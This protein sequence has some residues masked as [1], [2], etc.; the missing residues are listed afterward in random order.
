M[1]MLCCPVAALGQPAGSNHVRYGAALS[2]KCIGVGT[3]AITNAALQLIEAIVMVDYA[4]NC[5]CYDLSQNDT[6]HV[7][8]SRP[9]NKGLQRRPGDFSRFR[10]VAD[11]PEMHSCSRRI[12]Q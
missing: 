2:G 6:I 5:D 3:P 8:R 1:L 11:K 7:S 9:R 4:E 12:V 10:F